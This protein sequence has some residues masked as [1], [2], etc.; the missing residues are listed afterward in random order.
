MRA[1]NERVIQQVIKAVDPLLDPAERDLADLVPPYC[2][3]PLSATTCSVMGW[4]NS[5]CMDVGTVAPS[6]RRPRFRRASEPPAFCLT[7]DD[8]E[9]VRQ[10]ARHR[11][12]RSTHIATLG[13]GHNRQRPGDDLL[14]LAE[15]FAVR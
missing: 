5:T 15:R 1:N 9:I 13:D 12:T 8:V 11:L 10:V 4:Y 7:A 3:R 14:R 6:L 2:G